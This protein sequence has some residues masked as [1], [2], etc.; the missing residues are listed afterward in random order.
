M[1]WVFD[2]PQ[3]DTSILIL[4]VSPSNPTPGVCPRH[5]S[6]CKSIYHT[7]QIPASERIISSYRAPILDK[8]YRPRCALNPGSYLPL[9]PI[10]PTTWN[11]HTCSS[12][13]SCPLQMMHTTMRCFF[14]SAILVIGVCSLV[15]QRL[16]KSV[17]RQGR[18]RQGRQID[19]GVESD[20]PNLSGDLELRLPVVDYGILGI[21]L[22]VDLHGP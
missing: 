14:A 1:P 15:N 3:P 19:F 16:L 11:G 13:P 5:H 22:R 17:L 7:S 20:A 12:R 2:S 6:L 8:D 18:L 21:L 9:L 10:S 4:V